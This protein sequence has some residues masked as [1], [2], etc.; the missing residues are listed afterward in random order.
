MVGGFRFV[1]MHFIRCITVWILGYCVMITA[2]SESVVTS[3]CVNQI[4]LSISIKCVT[5]F[6][7]I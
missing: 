7:G 4:C 2:A 5:V 6:D 1:K 3:L